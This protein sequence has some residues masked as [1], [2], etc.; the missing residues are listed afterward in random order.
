MRA[1]ILLVLLAG[2]ASAPQVVTQKVEVPVPVLCKTP[3]VALPSY[4]FSP[5][6]TS[7]FSGVR[8]LMGDRDQALAYEIEL[9]AALAS[10]K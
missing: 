7:V 5:P 2:C 10:C 6:Y 3:D 4:H 9:R 8:D 1:L